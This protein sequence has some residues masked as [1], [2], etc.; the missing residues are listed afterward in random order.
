MRMG[1]VMQTLRK[2][3]T[4]ELKLL[5]R[6]PMSIVF[7]L[8]FPLVVLI[9]IT[10]S[11]PDFDEAFSGISTAVYYA[12]CFL[13]VVIAAVSL[14]VM[15]SHLAGYHEQGVL[16]RFHASGITTWQVV[17]SQVVVGTV[18]NAVSAVMLLIASWQIYGLTAPEQPI[19]VAAIL[20]PGSVAFLLVGSFIGLFTKNAR[21]A[22]ATGMLLFFP[23]WLL[24]GAGPPPDVMSD[25]MRTISEALPLT[26]L[27]AGIQDAWIGEGLN[28]SAVV[29]MLVIIALGLV[30]LRLVIDGSPVRSRS[31][32]MG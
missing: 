12:T 6:E 30:G 10:G 17:A 32:A 29:V 1:A 21:A 27:V 24:C 11:F 7:A 23:L 4:L 26:F 3:I 18:V 2:M 28:L 15:P 25:G 8:A 16:R 14:A 31:V 13:A 19:L 22:Q 9:V 20:V 5:V